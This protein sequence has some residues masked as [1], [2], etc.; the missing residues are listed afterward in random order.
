MITL[1]IGRPKRQ[2]A[3]KLKPSGSNTSIGG[4]NLANALSNAECAE[5][6]STTAA[7]KKS[8]QISRKPSVISVTEKQVSFA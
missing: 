4:T 6:T 3:T 7:K 2:V 5:A 1:Y 8:D